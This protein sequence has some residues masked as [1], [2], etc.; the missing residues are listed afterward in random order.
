MEAIIKGINHKK[1]KERQ[2]KKSE[3]TKRTKQ[4]AGNKSFFLFTVP[5]LDLGL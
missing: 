5:E 2:A 4:T 3:K 1:K